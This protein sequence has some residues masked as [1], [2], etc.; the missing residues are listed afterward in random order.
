MRAH[1]S[2]IMM[3]GALVL[4]EVSVGMIEASATR[5]DRNPAHAQLIVHDG[6]RIGP[7]PARADRMIGRLGVARDEVEQLGIRLRLGSGRDLLRIEPCQRAAPPSGA[8]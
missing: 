7:H 2:P 6:R 3:L 5:K 4:P 1:F 8:A